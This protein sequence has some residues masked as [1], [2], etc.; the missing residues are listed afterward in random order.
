MIPIE[1]NLRRV[2]KKYN[3]EGFTDDFDLKIP[4]NFEKFGKA[5]QIMDKFNKSEKLRERIISDG[6]KIF[7]E[8]ENVRDFLRISP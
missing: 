3:K 1:E 5:V 4:K 7:N 6:Q 2:L 8:T